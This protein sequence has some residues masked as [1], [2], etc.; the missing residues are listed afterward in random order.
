M[1]FST[2]MVSFEGKSCFIIT[3]ISSEGSVIRIKAY[4][5][6]DTVIRPILTEM[7]FT[8]IDP[9]EI[10]SPGSITN[11]I[12]NELINSDLVI[13]NLTG[14]NPNVMYELAVRHAA[15]KPIVTLAEQDTVIPF[16]I[17]AERTLKYFD[18]L[19]GA[20]PIKN[21]LRRAIVAAMK[22]KGQDNPIYRAI[23]RDLLAKEVKNEGFENYVLKALDSLLDFNRQKDEYE[24]FNKTILPWTINLEVT[25][26]ENSNA[27]ID[28][29][30]KNVHNWSPIIL[31][32]DLIKKDEESAWLQLDT[33]YS[34]SEVDLFIANQLRGNFSFSI[35]YSP[36]N[37]NRSL[38][39]YN[40]M[41]SHFVSIFSESVANKTDN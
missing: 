30:I 1:T 16:D 23:Q 22:T 9:L 39:N 41:K 7:G 28:D 20:E 32:Y 21:N 15:N 3:P 33:S 34:K 26:L 31:S 27:S 8:V 12:I 14:L 2:D 5:L 40:L 19:S 17:L 35:N 11:Q 29:L 24:N 37:L 6:I 4:S 13:A 25:R 18:S 36:V 10:A 38:N